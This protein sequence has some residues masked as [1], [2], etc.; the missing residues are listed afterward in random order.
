MI[1]SIATGYREELS[2]SFDMP[3]MIPRKRS[4]AEPQP[5]LRV[6]G[7]T[8][9]ESLCTIHRMALSSTLATDQENREL[10][11]APTSTLPIFHAAYFSSETCELRTKKACGECR[12]ALDRIVGVQGCPCGTLGHRCRCK[13]GSRTSLRQSAAIPAIFMGLA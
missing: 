1:R 5:I 2:K 13:R 10:S 3:L 9:H 8:V 7:D 11:Q 4:K 12:D 6:F